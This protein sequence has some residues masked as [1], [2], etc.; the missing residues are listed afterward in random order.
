MPGICSSVNC[1]ASGISTIPAMSGWECSRLAT[2]SNFRR[3]GMAAKMPAACSGRMPGR[4]NV[5]VSNT[6]SVI[7]NGG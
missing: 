2:I 5:R 3:P 7:H 6:P 1:F 4:S